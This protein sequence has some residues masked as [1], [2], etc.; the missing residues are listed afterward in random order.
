ME[1][2]VQKWGHSLAVRIPKALAQEVGLYEASAVTIT[3]RDGQLVVAPMK[4]RV[5]LDELLATIT[6]ESLHGEIDTGPAL[7]A[8]VW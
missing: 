3:L 1:T 2:R 6:P 7:G 4:P 5:T 8:E